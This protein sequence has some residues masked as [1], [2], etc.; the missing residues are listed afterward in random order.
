MRHALIVGALLVAA[1]ALAGQEAG[2]PG[3]RKIA[4][5]FAA[6]ERGRATGSVNDLRAAENA[7]DDAVHDA[8]RLANPL[9]GRALVKLE[10][11]ARDVLPKA[12]AGQR[13]GETNYAAFVRDAAAA[14]QRDSTFP[15]LI[16]LL[17][18]ILPPQG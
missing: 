16:A 10:L 12:T 14:L 5:G 2:E 3:A 15:P 8:P 11:T 9:F 18:K 17:A 13:I 4:M 7:F 1:P 6:L